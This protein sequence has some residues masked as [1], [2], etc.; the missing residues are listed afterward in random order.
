LI[1]TYGDSASSAFNVN[2]WPEVEQAWGDA[3]NRHELYAFLT[4]NMRSR[5]DRGSKHLWAAMTHLTPS[6]WQFL[7]KSTGGFRFLSDSI[8]REVT[9]WYRDE[10]WSSANIVA[11]DFFLGN[12]IIEESVR[13]NR[14][15]VK[16]CLN[17]QG[18]NHSNLFGQYKPSH[19]ALPTEPT[20]PN[21]DENDGHKDNDSE[22]SSGWL[23]WFGF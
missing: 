21:S 15:R 4:G 16:E 7:S 17:V 23:S 3:R 1:V 8:A 19:A 13:S 14:R 11:T 5:K 18:S 9:K 10:W 12:N 6:A 20:S 2:L 22:T